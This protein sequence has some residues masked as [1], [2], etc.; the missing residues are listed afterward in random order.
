MQRLSTSRDCDKWLSVT[1]AVKERRREGREGRE[2]KEG[3]EKGGQ[4]FAGTDEV[5]RFKTQSTTRLWSLKWPAK[6]KR[7]TASPPTPPCLF[8]LHGEASSP[9][10]SVV[11][12]AASDVS[13]LHV[14]SPEVGRFPTRPPGGVTPVCSF[15]P[16]I[17]HPFL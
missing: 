14:P 10:T 5:G 15:H 2:G 12:A 6:A 16:S 9:F 1:L 4:G 17:R 11:A 7:L 13:F 8:V 3:R